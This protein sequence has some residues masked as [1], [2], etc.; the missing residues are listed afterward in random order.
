MKLTKEM[1]GKRVLYKDTK[2]CIVTLIEYNDSLA[3]IALPPNAPGVFLGRDNGLYELFDVAELMK[4]SEDTRVL[5]PKH[6]KIITDNQNI[7]DAISCLAKELFYK[8]SN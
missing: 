2:Y 3:I 8:A 5:I 1:R 6:Y 7:I 4:Y